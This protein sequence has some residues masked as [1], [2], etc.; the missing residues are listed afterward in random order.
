MTILERALAKQPAF[1]AVIAFLAMNALFASDATAAAQSD[2]SS[3]SDDAFA[4]L[5]WDT[6][7]SAVL[8]PTTYSRPSDDASCL[9]ACGSITDGRTGAGVTQPFLPPMVH[10][11]IAAY[12]NG[13]SEPNQAKVMR[14][15]ASNHSLSLSF[16]ARVGDR[17]LPVSNIHF[18]V[19][20][21]DK[22]R[23]V[24]SIRSGGPILLVDLPAGNYEIFAASGGHSLVQRLKIRDGMHEHL[25]FGWAAPGPKWTVLSNESVPNAKPI[26]QRTSNQVEALHSVEGQRGG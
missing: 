9:R 18:A 11:G 13:G 21:V 14:K 23:V 26:E 16:V 19:T 3:G 5:V 8:Q 25:I 20:S 17:D 24:L 6:Q 2:C 7:H 10:A 1:L 4:G 15:E 12:R 22:T